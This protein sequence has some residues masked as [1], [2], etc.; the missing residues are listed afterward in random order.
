MRKILIFALSILCFSC[1]P[2]E[3]EYF[4]YIPDINDIIVGSWW[5]DYYFYY[6]TEDRVDYEDFQSIVRFYDDNTGYW[7][8]YGDK[9]EFEYTI[10]D[11]NLS[12]KFDDD[13]V[14]NFVIQI[15]DISEMILSCGDSKRR[16]IKIHFNNVTTRCDLYEDI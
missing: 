10:N 8:F 6:G 1:H 11:D 16:T 13:V 9:R 5:N 15:D 14:H 3:E 12:I 2:R 4:E 7:Y